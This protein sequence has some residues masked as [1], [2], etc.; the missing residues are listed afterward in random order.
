MALTLHYMTGG[1]AWSIIAKTGLKLD[2]SAWLP[3]EF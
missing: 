2:M 3:V 1:E